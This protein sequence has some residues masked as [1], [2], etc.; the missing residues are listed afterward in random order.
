MS[1]Y[2]IEPKGIGLQAAGSITNHPY[3]FLQPHIA[4]LVNLCQYLQ[5]YNNFVAYEITSNSLETLLEQL[6]PYDLDERTTN[7]M[8]DVQKHVSQSNK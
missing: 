1:L 7:R 6:N 4:L 3:S 8:S 5:P 2:G